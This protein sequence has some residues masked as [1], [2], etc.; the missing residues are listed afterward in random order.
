MLSSSDAF[1]GGGS[2]TCGGGGFCYGGM[3]PQRHGDCFRSSASCQETNEFRDLL[4][5]HKA[6][7]VVDF[8]FS[9]MLALS[10]F[11]VLMSGSAKLLSCLAVFNALDIVLELAM[12]GLVYDKGQ[13]GGVYCRPS[14]QSM[15]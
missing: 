7:S 13:G 9:T 1:C 11:L 12:A 3:L 10:Q 4:S 14:R 15:L 5:T 6:L 8:T 2:A